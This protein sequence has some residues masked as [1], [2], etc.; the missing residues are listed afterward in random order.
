M[1]RADV[2]KSGSAE[3][4]KHGRQKNEEEISLT[5]DLPTFQASGL[6]LCVR[7]GN[8]KALCPTHMEFLNE[9]LSAR[10]RMVLLKKLFSGEIDP[11]DA[12]DDRI[13]S[14]MLCGACDSLCPRG[15]SVTDAVYEG[16]R[17]LA[18]TGKKHR[19]FRTAIKYA[20]R[21]PANSFKILQ[22]LESAGLLL[23]LSRIQ[24]F[25]AL[26]ELQVRIPH[27]RLKNG[28]SVFKVPEP[29]GRI[30][31]FSG[32]T[33]DFLYPAMGLSLIYA[34]NALDFEVVL[35]KGEVCCGAPLLAMGLRE[36][37]SQLAE[38]N[39]NAFKKMQ[40]EA[41]ISLCPTCTHFIKQEYPKIIG[42]SIG[43]AMDI[44]Q[45]ICD[46]SLT[47]YL[48]PAAEPPGKVIYHDP[49]HSIHYLG[50][51]DEPRKI[52]RLLGFGIVEPA[53][54]GCC[55]FGGTV[56]VLHDYVSHAISETRVESFEGA[57]MI[58]TSCPNCVLQ[59]SSRIK[60]RPVKHIIEVIA[61]SL[62]RR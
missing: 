52:L 35:P 7:C 60:D 41:V 14:C 16:R 47:A 34:L 44:S 26:R 3:A 36:E 61:G 62:K 58:V 27:S 18:S 1:D 31:L 56:R 28:A 6:D 21:D 23:P 42:D 15:L 38:K 50:V 17:K 13:Y 57:E 24:P 39:L 12:L 8:C 45:F 49:C 46:A 29:R 20:F 43:N 37:A 5:S 59:F 33:V 48:T 40:V 25:K 30:A 54:K 51:N 10:G 32:C 55:G 2:R 53:E 11:S 22:F 19:L 4:Q 9:S